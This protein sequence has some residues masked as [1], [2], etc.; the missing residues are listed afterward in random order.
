M[1]NTLTRRVEALEAKDYG[2]EIKT[3]FVLSIEVGK[4]NPSINH[5][6]S[7]GQ[8]WDRMADESERDFKDRASLQVARNEWGAAILIASER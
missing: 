3:I 1:Q 5:I 8:V 7:S 6:K 2:N 4:L